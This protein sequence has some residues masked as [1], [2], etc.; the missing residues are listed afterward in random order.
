MVCEDDGERAFAF[1][2][3]V[4]GAIA[5]EDGDEGDEAAPPTRR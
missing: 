4:V 5:V 3:V 1:G 2:F